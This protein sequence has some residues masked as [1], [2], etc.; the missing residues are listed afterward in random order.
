MF[1]NEF[2][3]IFK[4][5][6]KIT[7]NRGIVRINCIYNNDKKEYFDCS[8]MEIFEIPAKSLLFIEVKKTPNYEGDFTD[9][10]L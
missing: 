8:D 2:D 5:D 10:F 9:L 1:F 4:V 6:N 3:A 7:L